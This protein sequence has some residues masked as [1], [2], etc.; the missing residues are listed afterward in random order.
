MGDPRV[1]ENC[2]RSAATA[3]AEVIG[4]ERSIDIVDGFFTDDFGGYDVDLYRIP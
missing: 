1:P 3:S 4:E 2:V